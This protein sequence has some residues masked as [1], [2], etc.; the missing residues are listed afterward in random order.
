MRKFRL[1]LALGLLLTIFLQGCSG[2][3]SSGGKSDSGDVIKVGLLTAFSGG[4]SLYGPPTEKAAQLAIDEINEAGGLL[5]KQLK[6]VVGDTATDPKTASERAKSLIDKD[7]VTA[8]FSELTSAEREAVV[9]VINK[10]DLLYF[11]D[12]IYE[13][14][15]CAHNMFINAEVPEQQIKPVIPYLIKELDASN[16]FIV[17]SDYVYGHK[18]GDA[19]REAVEGNDGKIVGEEYSPLGTTDY[20]SLL[21]KIEKAKPDFIAMAMIG[22]AVAFMK[23]F[24]QRGLNKDIKVLAFASDENTVEAMGEAAVGML[25]PTAYFWDQDTQANTE[26]KEKYF[27][28]FGDDAPKQNFISIPTYDAIHSWALAVKEADTFET[29]KVKEFLTQVTFKGPRGEITYDSS[30]HHANLPIYLGE[31]QSDLTFK[32]IHELGVIS[33]GNQCSF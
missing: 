22:D 33:P 16:W 12:D 27:D 18:S 3:T 5:G 9:P 31:V 21:T 17:G 6:L 26:F 11:Y 4:G 28:A 7:K 23:Q 10:E 25:E 8:I 2:S 15:A 20:S 13:G 19:V 29:E 14:G 30:S 32:V 1:F 24:H